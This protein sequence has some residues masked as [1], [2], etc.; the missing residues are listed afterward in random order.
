MTV[1]QQFDASLTEVE[2]YVKQYRDGLITAYE[3]RCA[4]IDKINEI[5]TAELIKD[6]ERNLAE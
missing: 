4:I 1:K 6:H 5:D 2:A 3:C